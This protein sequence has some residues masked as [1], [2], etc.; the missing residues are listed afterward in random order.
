[1]RQ[2]KIVLADPPPASSVSAS[3]T[4]VASPLKLLRITIR[5]FQ[6]SYYT[7][8]SD[9]SATISRRSAFSVTS[10]PPPLR[11]SLVMT[12][13]LHIS[14]IPPIVPRSWL[15]L[16]SHFHAAMPK[17]EPVP[18]GRARFVSD[19]TGRQSCSP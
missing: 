4:M 1:M 16:A 3:P 5:N 15:L 2:P 6:G 14:L 18:V 13:P 11:L 12:T 19:S 10:P 7:C 8:G 17:Q 9:D